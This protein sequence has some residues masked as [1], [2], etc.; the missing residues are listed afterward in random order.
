MQEPSCLA[1]FFGAG[2]NFPWDLADAFDAACNGLENPEALA[3]MEKLRGKEFTDWK[4]LVKAIRAMYRGD[5]ESC[6]E[7]SD[8]IESSSTPASLKS[9]FAAWISGMK[10]AGPAEASARAPGQRK[11]GAAAL[12]TGGNSAVPAMELYRKLLVHPHPLRLIAEQAD[13]A[14]RQGMT[15]HFERLS[16]SVFRGLREERRCDSALLALRYARYCLSLLNEGGYTQTDFFS[17]IVRVLGRADG[18][19]VIGLSLL[20]NDEE[21][22]LG[23]LEAAL[24]TRVPEEQASARSGEDPDGSAFLDNEMAPALRAMIN[25]MRKESPRMPVKNAKPSKRGRVRGESPGQLELF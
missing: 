2:E 15:G 4:H 7:A 23:A 6:R 17:L 20:D 12:M 9:L 16:Q 25:L 18:F 10:N 22:A 11:P 14:L 13:E 1:R 24:E 19:L 8:S 3:R 5:A 21:A